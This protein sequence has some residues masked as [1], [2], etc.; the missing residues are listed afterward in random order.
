LTNVWARRGSR[1]TALQQTEYQWVYL[2]ASTNAC[3][4]ESTAL[5]APSVSTDLMNT[6]LQHIAEQVGPDRHVVLVLD[7]AGWHVARALRIPGNI[8]FLP[9]PS[10]SPQL[11]A[12]ERPWGYLRQHY[13]S[14]RVY[15]DYDELFTA[16]SEAWN[17]LSQETLRS[18]CA[19]AWVTRMN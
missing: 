19:T 16:T 11:N 12:A 9:L 13:L 14:N 8:T 2:F 10:Y 15:K 7:N 4:G 6:H 1:P 5:I 17:R 3:T 18:L